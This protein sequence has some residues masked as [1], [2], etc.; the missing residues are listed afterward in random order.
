M[1]L[2]LAAILILV[3]GRVDWGRA[4]LFVLVT[5]GTQIVVGVMLHRITPDL[6]AERSR[7]PKDT[8]RWDKLLAPAVAVFGPLI[9]WFVAAWDVRVHWPPPVSLPWS[10]AAFAVCIPA[11]L[12]TAWAMAVNR[13]FT[14]TVR[15]QAE[16]GHMVVD[17]GPYRHLRHPGYTGALVFTLASPLALGSW[18]ALL[19]AALVAALLIV[20]TALEDR[21]LR[22]RLEGYE[23]YARRTPRRL[24]PGVW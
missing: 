2:V 15:I 10:I 19:P 1:G 11:I 5:L 21:T 3:S 24:V 18:L 14:S 6:L 22:A 20:R 4:W 7:F 17:G 13:F 8:E 9:L 16:R 12:L 23:E